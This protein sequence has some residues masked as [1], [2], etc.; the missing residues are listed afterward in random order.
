MNEQEHCACGS[1]DSVNGRCLPCWEIA[2]SNTPGG[3]IGDPDPYGAGYHKA[4]PLPDGTY[5]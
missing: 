1:P 3:L 5:D 4:T 2:R